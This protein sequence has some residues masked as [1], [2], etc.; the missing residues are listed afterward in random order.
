[1][2]KKGRQ[3]ASHGKKRQKRIVYPVAKKFTTI[4]A[5]SSRVSLVAQ[6]WYFSSFSLQA[7][8]I[9]SVDVIFTSTTNFRHS[10]PETRRGHT[11]SGFSFAPATQPFSFN[12][13]DRQCSIPMVISSL[14]VFTIFLSSNFCSLV[15]N[16][17]CLGALLKRI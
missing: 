7:S 6:S 1:M 3:Q 16:P 15:V 9:L 11:R 8:F 12:S 5:L 4:T 10:S 13:S 17:L 2:Q 14:A